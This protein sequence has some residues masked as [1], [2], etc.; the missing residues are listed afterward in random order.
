[1]NTVER[2]LS[3]I[4]QHNITAAHLLRE[5]KLS[6]ASITQWKKGLYNPSYGA[7]VKIADYFNVSV[8]YLQ[9]HTDNP[10]PPKPSPKP[11]VNDVIKLIGREK[12]ELFEAF[13]KLGK[14][15]KQKVIGYAHGLAEQAQGRQIQTTRP[16]K[17]RKSAE[18]PEN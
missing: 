6:L 7:L 10:E 8:E 11:T 17:S 15:D 9:G 18:T 13:D 1:M 14:K 2:I 12:A 3:L 4:E 5:V 16:K